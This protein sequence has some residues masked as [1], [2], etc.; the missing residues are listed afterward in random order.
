[1][2][3]TIE[4]L[5]T[6]RQ[7]KIDVL[8]DLNW[9][10]FS[11]DSQSSYSF[12]VNNGLGVSYLSTLPW[13]DRL[14]EELSSSGDAGSGF[15]LEVLTQGAGTLRERVLDMHN[16]NDDLGEDEEPPCSA[17]IIIQDP[18]IGYFL[19]TSY[20]N[21]PLAVQFD[22]PSS[23]FLEEPSDL[24]QFTFTPDQSPVTMTPRPSYQPA[25]A[26]YSGSP[27]PEF[28]AKHA[29]ERHRRHLK[30]EI[31]LSPATLELMTE[32]HRVLSQQTHLLGVAAAELFRRCERIQDEFREQIKRCRE[33][34]ERTDAVTGNHEDK[35]DSED[36]SK[37]P[38]RSGSQRIDQR[39]HDIQSRQSDLHTRYAALRRKLAH[40]LGEDMSEK[41]KAWAGEVENMGKSVLAPSSDQ[42]F[43][44]RKTDQP[45]YRY[46]E[47]RAMTDELVREADL[48][49]RNAAEGGADDA[50]AV[51]V[52]SEIRKKKIGQVMGL[53]EREYVVPP[54]LSLLLLSLQHLSQL[55]RTTYASLAYTNKPRKQ[56]RACRS[57]QIEVTEPIARMK[58]HLV[59]P[60]RSWIVLNHLH[61]RPFIN[62]FSLPAQSLHIH[63]H[64]H[65]P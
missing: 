56:I 36:E 60:F 15:R 65:T 25:R 30:S 51:K 29:Q 49:V 59:F 46:Q 53:L 34:A 28:F 11:K 50:H 16:I 62:S 12:F 40:H 27:L 44:K 3:L 45:W 19:L 26:F 21:E 37:N 35:E 9:P 4:Y 7:E 32:A 5:D 63:I 23:E 54:F 20:N 52:P 41:E 39:I 58:E 31:R 8:S 55:P 10:T 17:S 2:L 24:P 13:V 33:I 6:L 1:M 38:L 47:A 57:N 18:S 48:A 64:T 43:K 22:H 61:T 42:D 14:E